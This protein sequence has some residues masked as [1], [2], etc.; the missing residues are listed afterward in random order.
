[1]SSPTAALDA[2][3]Q[4]WTLLPCTLFLHTCP[5]ASVRA[6]WRTAVRAALDKDPTHHHLRRVLDA[7][8]FQAVSPEGVHS[9]CDPDRSLRFY[10]RCNGTDVYRRHIETLI[11]QEPD[12]MAADQTTYMKEQILAHF[13]LRGLETA[14]V[15]DLVSLFVNG[16]RK[17]QLASRSASL[18]H[19]SSSSSSSSAS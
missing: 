3:L 15:A 5:Q 18:S 17:T 12:P 11:R 13:P 6:A 1:M 14:S 19:N 8:V 7:T 2:F 16:P 10:E 9:I 4:Q